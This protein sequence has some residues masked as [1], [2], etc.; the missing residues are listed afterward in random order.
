MSFKQICEET[1]H[2]RKCF[3]TEDEAK[4][5][6]KWIEEKGYGDDIIN[7]G[8]GKFL[9]FFCP[10]C[11]AYHVKPNFNSHPSTTCLDSNNRPKDEYPTKED[12]EGCLKH[13]REKSNKGFNLHVYACPKCGKFHLTHKNYE[14]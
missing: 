5:E 2:E 4:A 8:N 14:N 7:S 10:T 3:E 11:K 1:K 6:V 13:M 12:A 9:I